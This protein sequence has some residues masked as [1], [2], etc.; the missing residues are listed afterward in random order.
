VR[1]PV[2]QTVPHQPDELSYERAVAGHRWAVPERFN[3]A[4][5]VRDKHPREKLAMVHEHF[6]GTVRE[7]SWG[8]LQDLSNKFA[9]VLSSLDV[10]RGCRSGRRA[11]AGVP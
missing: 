7:V 10:A 11:A 4:A 8:E 5:D 9:N 2:S 3:I 1:Q 6:S